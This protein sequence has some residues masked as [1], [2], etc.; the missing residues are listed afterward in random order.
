MI[1]ASIPVYMGGVRPYPE[2][3]WQRLNSVTLQV[4]E[5]DKLVDVYRFDTPPEDGL[6][7]N[8]DGGRTRR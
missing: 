1:G 3:W 5:C 6:Q 4:G 8:V 7:S 2:A